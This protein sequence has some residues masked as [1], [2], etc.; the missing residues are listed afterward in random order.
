MIRDAFII[1]RK[2]LK[3]L[4]KDK[5]T[6][7]FIIVFPLVLMPAIFSTMSFV[8]ERQQQDAADTIYAVVIEN[9]TDERFVS[10][11]SNFLQF[12]I[13]ENMSESDLAVI[14]PE[15]Y[16]PGTKASV[17][18]YYDSTSTKSNFASGRIQAALGVYSDMLAEQRL[19]ALDLSLRDLRSI[20]VKRVDTA[21]EEAQGAGFMAILLP[22]LIIIYVFT[23]SMNIGLDTTAGEKERGSLASILVNQVSRTSIA[24]G[25][26]MYVIVAGLLNSVSSFI[27]IMIALN[28]GGGLFGG[29]TGASMALFSPLN[30]VGLLLVLLSLS[31]FAASVIVLLGSFA[32]NMKEGA[33]YIMP[34]YIIV[35]IIGVA[36]MQMDPAKSLQMF[37]IPL[38]NGVFVLKELLLGQLQ[39]L[40]MLVTLLTNGAAAAV[41]IGLTARLYNTEKILNTI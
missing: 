34:I 39:F 4:A 18:L 25:K 10:N 41:L 8:T 22:Y 37:F 20:E 9:N 36:S 1:L 27:G 29:E 19:R 35:I 30:I 40:H 14:F 16:T 31:S 15:N 2:E 23:G 21:P 7:L 26:V 17:D 3:N 28:L 5:R 11:L 33:S 24:L 32:K 13:V 38:V 12:R 6:L